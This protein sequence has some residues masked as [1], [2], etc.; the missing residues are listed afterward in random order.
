[1]FH[2]LLKIDKVARMAGAINKVTEQYNLV[3]VTKFRNVT[4]RDFAL[5]VIAHILTCVLSIPES[6]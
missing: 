2:R 4:K 1:M 5:S 6:H 3:V